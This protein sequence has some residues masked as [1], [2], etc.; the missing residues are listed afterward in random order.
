MTRQWFSRFSHALI[1]IALTF[2]VGR[3]AL[4]L[5]AA[6]S[7]QSGSGGTPV[8]HRGGDGDTGEFI[9]RALLGADLHRRH[10]KPS[11]P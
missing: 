9:L 3:P 4:G 5:I 6:Q 11:R 1:V 8:G 7:G 10:R 2:G